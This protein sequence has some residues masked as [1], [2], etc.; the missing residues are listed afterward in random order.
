LLTTYCRADR[1]LPRNFD[2]VVLGKKERDI[3]VACGKN[4]YRGEQDYDDDGNVTNTLPPP[5]EA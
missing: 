1:V 2:L 5:D 3:V 4:P